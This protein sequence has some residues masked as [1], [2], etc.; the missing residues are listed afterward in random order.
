MNAA[1]ELERFLAAAGE[2]MELPVAAEL[3][4]N[5]EWHLTGAEGVVVRLARDRGGRLRKGRPLPDP[6][7]ALHCRIDQGPDLLPGALPLTLLVARGEVAIA[8][9][10]PA[11]L[12]FAAGW[13][14]LRAEYR[15]WRGELPAPPPRADGVP[16]AASG[17]PLGDEL[18]GRLTRAPMDQALL[19]A[20]VIAGLPTPARAA[21]LEHV[22][23]LTT[24]E[25]VRLALAARLLVSLAD[26]ASGTSDHLTERADLEHRL[27]APTGV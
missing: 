23:E 24:R 6:T 21:Q 3:T 8:G 1:G 20:A 27:A 26:L 18:P 25:P 2:A 15:A 10:L 5:V 4:R 22:I 16:P 13:E 12:R 19:L 9:E 17:P 14:T 7:L 11:A